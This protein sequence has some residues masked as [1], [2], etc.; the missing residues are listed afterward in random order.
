MSD[1]ASKGSNQ[2]TNGI[3]KAI[4]GAKHLCTVAT[5]AS[6]TSSVV[7]L[8]IVIEGITVPTG[9]SWGQLCTAAAAAADAQ[10]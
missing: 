2:N 8:H 3:E 4:M 5:R 1:Q 10:Y 9:G 6:V 7:V